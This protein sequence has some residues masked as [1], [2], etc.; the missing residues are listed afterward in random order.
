MS[1]LPKVCVGVDV[2]N[3]GVCVVLVC[4]CVCVCMRVCLRACVGVCVGVGVGVGGWVGGWWGT[5]IHPHMLMCMHTAFT[6]GCS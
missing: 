6:C 3:V 4:V 2:H 5:F 1:V